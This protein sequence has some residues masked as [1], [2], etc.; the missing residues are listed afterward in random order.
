LTDP[1]PEMD[2][3]VELVQVYVSMAVPPDG[4]V[5]VFVNN[6]AVGAG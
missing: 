5:G 2:A 6:V 3:D 4:I 1:I